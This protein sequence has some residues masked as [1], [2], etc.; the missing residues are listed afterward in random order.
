MLVTYNSYEHVR[1]AAG[2]HSTDVALVPS[3]LVILS[4]MLWF[5]IQHYTTPQ[6]VHWLHDMRVLSTRR[7]PANP[8]SVLILRPREIQALVTK[9]RHRDATSKCCKGV[10]NAMPYHRTGY[11]RHAIRTPATQQIY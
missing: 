4:N 6:N 3:C 8:M 1:G 7:H 2:V 10:D 11:D 5:V 9:L